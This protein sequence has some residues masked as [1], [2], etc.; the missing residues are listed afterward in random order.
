MPAAIAFFGDNIDEITKF[1]LAVTLIGG[2]LSRMKIGPD[3]DPNELRSHN[4]VVVGCL[5]ENANAN[6]KRL[7][8]V[9]RLS[10][11]D[12]VVATTDFAP[13]WAKRIANLRMPRVNEGLYSLLEMVAK[14]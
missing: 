2:T 3:S 7:I 1:N 5:S 14:T 11:P 13:W 12:L 10:R 8:A 4:C 6:V 9:A